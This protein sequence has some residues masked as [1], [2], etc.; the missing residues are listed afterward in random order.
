[1]I[2]SHL[3]T[4]QLSKPDYEM[5]KRLEISPSVADTAT[6][7]ILGAELTSILHALVARYGLV[8]ALDMWYHSVEA[9]A[10][11]PKGEQQHDN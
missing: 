11:A 2:K 1:M 7:A 3:G 8:D 5:A 10:K 9:Y 4:V 6:K